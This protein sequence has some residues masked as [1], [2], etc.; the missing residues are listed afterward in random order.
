[1]KWCQREEWQEPFGEI[2]ALHLGEACAEGGIAFEELPTVIGDYFGVLWGCAFED[3]LT[4]EGEDGSNITDNYLKRRG[5]NESISNKRYMAALRTSVMS[6]YEV[7]DIVRDEGLLARDLI[8]GGEPVRVCEKSGTHSL[9]QWDR[10]AARLVEIDGHFEMTGGCL[11]FTRDLS[12]E[13]LQAF[14][15]TSK[16][17]HVPLNTKTLRQAAHLF[18]SLWL[19]DALERTLRPKLPELC[20]SDGDD[21]VWTTVRYRLKPAAEADAVRN[22]LAT[23]PSLRPE[24]KGFWN[25]IEPKRSKSKAAPKGKQT[26]VTELDDGAVVL[27]TLELKSKT[28]TLE[29]NSPQRA[30]RGRALIEP[31]LADLVGL[32]V[33]ES[34]TVAEMMASHS[35]DG[36][37]PLSSGLP[38]EDERTILHAQM[39]RYYTAL[40]DEPVPALGNKTPRQVA[41]TAKGRQKLA[42][43]LK[44]LENGTAGQDDASA[45]AGYDFA[46]MWKELG[47]AELRR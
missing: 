33:L 21:I 18:T 38:S 16:K 9:K 10:I 3:F 27:G 39:D 40:L 11:P 23:V 46:W 31:V 34:R 7:S 29:T 1:M 5:W 42:G 25:W 44:Y 15:A 37:E 45:M 2:L 41:K 17:T 30:Q 12:E 32:P 14:R 13:L 19:S 26:L 36:S 8:R 6:L 47:I 24:N 20:N 22:R 28:L 4:Q 43:W 35:G